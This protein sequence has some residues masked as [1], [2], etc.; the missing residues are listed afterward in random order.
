VQE[1]GHDDALQAGDD[2]EV[3]DRQHALVAA[4]VRVAGGHA[5]DPFC[6]LED[7]RDRARHSRSPD[8]Y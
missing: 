2:Q 4:V 6:A 7:R 3:R 1:R 5:G 8:P